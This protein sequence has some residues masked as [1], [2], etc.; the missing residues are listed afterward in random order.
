ML[1]N[2]L[3]RYVVGVENASAGWKSKSLQSKTHGQLCVTLG[4]F[5]SSTVVPFLSQKYLT[6]NA[7]G[8]TK[9]SGVIT[10]L[11]VL[12]HVS[13]QPRPGNQYPHFGL[14]CQLEP[15]SQQMTTVIF[16]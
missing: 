13:T 10:I 12:W 5:V 8:L 2:A 15:V 6:F 9:V 14:I 4:K 16:R 7:N 1:V 3:R 11:G